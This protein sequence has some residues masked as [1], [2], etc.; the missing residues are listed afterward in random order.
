MQKGGARRCRRRRA[1]LR[2]NPLPPYQLE[3]ASHWL[4]DGMLRGIR[5]VHER[6][7]L[8]DDSARTACHTLLMQLCQRMNSQR[9]EGALNPGMVSPL[10]SILNA[11]L[12]PT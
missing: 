12:Q 3:S 7:L 8:N 9:S 6:P 1:E 10:V 11:T 5:L 2:H 4:I